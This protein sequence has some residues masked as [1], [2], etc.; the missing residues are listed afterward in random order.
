[1]KLLEGPF[2]VHHHFI[3]YL[4]VVLPP[5]PLEEVLFESF[6]FSVL[7]LVLLKAGDEVVLILLHLLNLELDDLVFF[8]R[9]LEQ[10]LTQLVD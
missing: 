10:H 4:L 7:V 2:P 6:H 5:E 8:L 1:M 3:L 9:V